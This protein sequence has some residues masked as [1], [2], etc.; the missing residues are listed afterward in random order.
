MASRFWVG[1][2]GTWD[3]TTTTHWSATSGG[4]GG[5]SAPVTADDVTFD[6]SSGGGTV[7]VDTTVNGL[8]LNSIV[9]GAFTGTLDFSINNPSMTIGASGSPGFNISGSGIRTIKFGSGTFTIKDNNFLAGTITNLT[10]VGGS[11]TFNFTNVSSGSTQNFQGGGATWSGNTISIQGRT[12]TNYTPFF[13]TG[14]SALAGLNIT[15]PV[16][17]NA[18]SGTALTVANPVTWSGSASGLITI[19]S[20][21]FGFNTT[22]ATI[23]LTSGSTSTISWCDFIGLT[24]TGSAIA[25]NSFNG[26]GTTGITINAPSG[27]GSSL[28]AMIGS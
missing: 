22:K 19:V 11:A 27:G 17:L 3:S 21:S 9:A 8:S 18:A 13:I 24:F 20:D 6:A 1:G 14:V 23:N 26:G 25:N 5:A 16:A 4:A 10:L 28:G 12:G 7:T 2:T 15:G